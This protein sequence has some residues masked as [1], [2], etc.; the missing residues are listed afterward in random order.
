MIF[1]LYFML[2]IAEKPDVAKA[3]VKGLGTNFTSKDGYM[4]DGENVVTWCVGH[5]MKLKDPE[6]YDEKY[7]KWK[8]EDLPFYFIPY[9]RKSISKVAKQLKTVK[10]LI[11]EAD[12]IVNAGDPDDEGQLL[13]DEILRDVN[14][15]KPVKRIFINDNNIKIVQKALANMEDNAK[16][17]YMG[18]RAEAR[19]VADQVLGYNLSRSYSLVHQ[20][21]T[22]TREVIS[23]GRVQSAILGLVVRRDQEHANHKSSNFY[24]LFGDFIIDGTEFKAK[25]TPTE[26][27]KTDEKGR[28]L[29]QKQATEIANYC[30]DKTA[31]IIDAETLEKT[32]VSPLPYNLIKLQ[33]DCAKKFGFNPSKTLKITQSLRENYQ[34]IT[35]NRSDCQYLSEEQHADAEN[36]FKHI[37][38]NLKDV[39]KPL[40]SAIESENCDSD[41]K[42]RAFDSSKVSAHHAIIPTENTVDF[43]KLSKDEI[44]VY[45]LIA[46]SYIA[47]FYPDYHYLQTKVN[48]AVDEYHFLVTSNL[49]TKQGWK[50]L[51]NELEDDSDNADSIS[52]DLRQLKAN[53]IGV[54]SDT[55]V[56]KEATKPL[57]LYT[58]ATLLSDLT[59]VAKYIQDENLARILK[60]RDK[61]KEG[62]NGGIGTPAT[63]DSIINTLFDRGFI[64]EQK[65]KIISTDLGKGLYE[66]LTDRLKYPDL[67]AIWTEKFE[68]IKSLKDIESFLNYV[69]KEHITPDV[70]LLKSEYHIIQKNEVTFPCPKCGR[71]M[72]LKNGK[73]GE[74]WGCV[75]YFDQ[76]NQ[77]KN[78]M[79]NVDGKPVEKEH[80]ELPKSDISCSKCGRDMVLRDGKFGEYWGCVGYFDKNNQCKNI[81]NN[82]DGKP[83]EK[84]AAAPQSN[85]ANQTGDNVFITVPF[86]EKDKVK[87]LGAKWDKDKKSWFIP[88][89]VDQTKFSKWL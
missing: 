8:F 39:N 59:R 4:T 23:V 87:A 27:Q 89:G 22:G 72:T 79:N 49:P 57:P 77:C 12:I 3:I 73:F 14:N 71:D 70:E 67:T 15:K 69:V 61:D 58:M 28:L 38:Q 41:I 68:E 44:Q 24:N 16:Y 25:F 30:K 1:G 50:V 37:F 19:A 83:V 65:K 52:T 78:I 64:V 62:E 74:Y 32:T 26:K 81:M 86:S 75:G 84:T 5:M 9:Q 51:F 60:E 17:E 33:Q 21:K 47:L 56:K 7:K 48:V 82:V 2:F 55:Q 31:I 11:K 53:N 43:S 76:D 66:Q 6:E 13:V 34:L 80:K 46:K 29:D 10:D 18:F 36:V 88:A 63:R 45:E 85:E 20:K 42:N 35:Y 54:C 40:C